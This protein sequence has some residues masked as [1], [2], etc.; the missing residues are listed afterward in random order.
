MLKDVEGCRR[1]L[2]DVE[3]NRK[4][5]KLRKASK[6]VETDLRE[7]PGMGVPL[8]APPFQGTMTQRAS[9]G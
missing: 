6:G 3:G 5:R 2:K 1:M 9:Q 7:I 4:S 8:T